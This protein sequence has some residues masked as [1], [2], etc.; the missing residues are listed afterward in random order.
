MSFTGSYPGQCACCGDPFDRGEELVYTFDGIVIADHI[1][2]PAKE[3][4]LCLKCFVTKSVTG[5]C[6]C[7]E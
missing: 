2:A 5:K 6:N 7:P 4:E 1:K 3:P